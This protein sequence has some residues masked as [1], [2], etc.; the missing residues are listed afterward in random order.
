VCYFYFARE[1]AGASSARLS[2]RP[3]FFRGATIVRNSGGSCREIADAR[4]SVASSLTDK[5]SAESLSVVE[6]PVLAK[7][8]FVDI[9]TSAL[10][11]LIVLS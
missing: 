10:S 2:L 7:R 5:V 8:P 4:L 6:W 1:A 11:G 9:C 3:L